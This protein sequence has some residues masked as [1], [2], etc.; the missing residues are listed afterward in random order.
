MNEKFV[1]ISIYTMAFAA[2]MTALPAYANGAADVASGSLGILSL[3]LL[4]LLLLV[5]LIPAIGSLTMLWQSW[6]PSKVDAAGEIVRWKPWSAL[7]FG[8]VAS[9]VLFFIVALLGQAGG[10]GG[11]IALVILFI[12]VIY[13]L[14]PGVSATIQW[15]GESIDPA[16]TGIRRALFGAGAWSLLI[17]FVVVG[18]MIMLGLVL[19]SVGSSIIAFHLT[20]KVVEPASIPTADNNDVPPPPSE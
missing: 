2:G 7:G 5:I 9:L 13:Y 18:W 11:L 19:M 1:K 14:I 15:I 20:K 16:S 3:L 12:Y 10:V 17:I 4:L 8:L 6:F